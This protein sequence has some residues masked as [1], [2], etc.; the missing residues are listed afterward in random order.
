MYS[1]NP[2]VAPPSLTGHE[3]RC[4][5]I[6]GCTAFRC[7]ATV[8][9]PSEISVNSGTEPG[10]EFTVLAAHQ[11]RNFGLNHKQQH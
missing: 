7:I 3:G 9:T 11:L 2:D 8:G 6:P 5:E 10:F 1:Q 4:A